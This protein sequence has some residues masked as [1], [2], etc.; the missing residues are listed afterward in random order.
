MK[1]EPQRNFLKPWHGSA[2]GAVVEK[3]STDP[4]PRET[5][6]SVPTVPIA[7]GE[8]T[9][10]LMSKSPSNK[11]ELGLRHGLPLTLTVGDSVNDILQQCNPRDSI[12]EATVPLHS[13]ANLSRVLCV[14]NPT[15]FEAHVQTPGILRTICLLSSPGSIL[16]HH[17]NH[18]GAPEPS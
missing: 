1:S 9:L 14:L 17:K 10:R 13:C 11:L 3:R 12:P 6:A 2:A 7:L 5:P 4:L 15:R 18:S 8:P 16:E